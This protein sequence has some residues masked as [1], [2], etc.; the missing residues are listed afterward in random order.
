MSRHLVSLIG[1]T[2]LI[3]LKAL[4]EDTGCE[5]LGKAEFLNPGG[6]V[7]DRAAWYI[8]S[9]AIQ[10]GQ[11]RP[12]GTIV[13][14]TAG[15]TG[16]GLS[17]VGNSLGY[18]S[19]IVVPE[20]QSPEKLQLLRA[21]GADLITVPSVFMHITGKDH[22]HNLLQARA[23]ETGCYII[24]PAQYG[25]YVN[26]RKSY[27]HSLIIS[28]WGKILED[29]KVDKNIIISDIDKNQIKEARQKIPS[30]FLN[31]SYKMN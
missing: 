12:G 7:K 11:L 5:I 6:S 15:N 26:K 14:G 13:E 19:T 9:D 25:H 23:I 21:C 2:P 17:L 1:N 10:T 20:T 29:A 30:L 31:K 27:G 28:P 22:W 4:S 3:K 18:R 8:I 16:I 24:A